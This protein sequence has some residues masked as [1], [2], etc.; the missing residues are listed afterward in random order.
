MTTTTTTACAPCT[1][2]VAGT[3][4]P[5]RVTGTS[6]EV[7]IA[8]AVKAAGSTAVEE[9]GTIAIMLSGIAK[10]TVR[11][12]PGCQVVPVPV[13]GPGI[14]RLGRRP[15]R[16]VVL[17][18]TLTI[19][20]TETLVVRTCWCG[21]AHAIPRSLSEFVDRKH[22]D[23]HEHFV[24]CP[25]GHAWTPAGKGEYLPRERAPGSGRGSR[26]PDR[27]STTAPRSAPTRRPRPRRRRLFTERPAASV[28][29]A[30]ARSSMSPVT[31]RASTRRRS[32]QNVTCEACGRT[33]DPVKEAGFQMVTA[34]RRLYPSTQGL[35]ARHAEQRFAC[36][37]CVDGFEKSG[38]QWSQP[39]LFG[40]AT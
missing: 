36:R 8:E 5:P 16:R 12:Y 19:E 29:I 22:R 7:A 14:D 25:L 6:I 27:R 15:V 17:I 11:G 23:G 13:Q 37:S 2:R 1:P 35:R 4:S 32:T 38:L 9:G 10:A 30:I 20:Y 33:F 21:M 24:Y 26:Q 3:S 18:V 31:S 39:S 34:W 28:C 40:D